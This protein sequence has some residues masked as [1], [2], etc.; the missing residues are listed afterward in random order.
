MICYSHRREIREHSLT[1]QAMA[2]AN[3]FIRARALDSFLYLPPIYLLLMLFL[4]IYY[5]ESTLYKVSDDNAQNYRV[6]QTAQKIPPPS[7][8]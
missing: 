4:I 7:C 2:T 1:T 3:R 8:E 5:F 6:G